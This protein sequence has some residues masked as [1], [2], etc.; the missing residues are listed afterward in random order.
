MCNVL[1]WSAV[2]WNVMQS[3]QSVQCIAVKCSNVHCNAVKCSGV[4]LSALCCRE[5]QFCALVCSVPKSS[6]GSVEGRTW[7][8]AHIY[9][10]C[11]PF[12]SVPYIWRSSYMC[13]VQCTV[14]RELHDLCLCFKAL[15]FRANTQICQTQDGEEATDLQTQLVL[16]GGGKM[17]FSQSWAGSHPKH[18]PT[19]QTF[20]L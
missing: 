18:K 17:V 1:Q 14:Y 7:Q 8:I 11:V 20:T 16:S 13:S 9:S 2:M 15:C 3:M 4:L 5:V 10:T 6:A 19:Q 12:F